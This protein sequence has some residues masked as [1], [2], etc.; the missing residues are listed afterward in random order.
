MRSHWIN[1]N[2][3]ALAKILVLGGETKK[4]Q[5]G[6]EDFR[7]GCLRNAKPFPPLEGSGSLKKHPGANVIK[8]PIQHPYLGESDHLSLLPHLV[9]NF[10]LKILSG[11]M[12]GWV[13]CSP[14]FIIAPYGGGYA[15]TR[16]YRY[17]HTHT[18]MQ[19]VL[20]HTRVQS[21]P[22][23]G[24]LNIYNQIAQL[25]LALFLT[26]VFFTQHPQVLSTKLPRSF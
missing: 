9:S 21:L 6:T 25:P 17:P 23:P 15:V 26:I 13:A 20:Y 24:D 3:T 14:F 5:G 10:F 19:G 2:T 1:L 22:G 18:S 7:N 4:P 8:E 11:Q 16:Y 12:I